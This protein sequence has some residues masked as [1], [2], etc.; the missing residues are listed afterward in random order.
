M[1]ST[2]YDLFY[3]LEDEHWWFQ[4]RKELVLSLLQRHLPCDNP[5][6]L[7]VG[8]GTGGML[9]GYQELGQALG[10]DTAEEAAHFCH[11][12]GLDMMLGS[13]TEL[14]F[15]DESVDVVSAL[16]VIEH[17][18]DDRGILAEMHR[19]CRRNGI[20]LLT[21]PAFQ[22]LWSN[23]DVLNHHKRRYVRQGIAKLL[24]GT[25]FEPLKLSYYNSFLLPAAVLR[26]WVLRVRNHG[27]ESH[28]EYV[29]RPINGIFRKILELEGPVLARGDFPVGASIICAAR[30]LA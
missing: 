8:C 2:L 9:A 24:D 21:V 13:G 14:P 5:R 17:V 27:T 29:P 12:R 11:L 23:H 25:G 30:R 28:L 10:V 19:V 7:D 22:F 15:A 16:D 4:G 18:D 3:E 20:L 26:K 6:I 1:D